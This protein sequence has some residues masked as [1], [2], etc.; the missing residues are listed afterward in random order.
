MRNK[1]INKSMKNWAWPKVQSK[2]P[3]LSPF[4][5][6]DKDGVIN[7]HDC[8]PFNKWRQEIIDLMKTSPSK[9]KAILQNKK[10][11]YHKTEY[12][13]VPQMLK[14][15]KLQRGK[16][17]LSTSEISN[18][19]VIYKKYNEPVVLVLERKKLNNLK[20]INYDNPNRNSELGT[21]QYRSEREWT[22][23]GSKTKQA[24]KGVILNEK[25]KE[26]MLPPEEPGLERVSLKSYPTRYATPDE[27]EKKKLRY[28]RTGEQGEA[29]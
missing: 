24:L 9:K 21:V 4:A 6:S 23:T 13:V 26:S 29:I 5:D 11:L 18:P 20:K 12:K 1:R 14:S 15:N 3:R 25:V 16:V 22:T 28:K 7:I 27:F 8:K 10:Y 17:P 19:N 2:Y